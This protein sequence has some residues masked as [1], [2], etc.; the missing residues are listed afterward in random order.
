MAKDKSVQSS[1]K[2]AAGTSTERVTMSPISDD[3]MDEPL[4]SEEAGNTSTSDDEERSTSTP[5]DDEK[6]DDGED[7]A[8]SLKTKAAIGKSHKVRG[9][10]HLS[11]DISG[12][13]P[14]MNTLTDKK[15]SEW[16]YND[17]ETIRALWLETYTNALSEWKMKFT[18]IK[19]RKKPSFE[20]RETAAQ[21]LR[22]DYIKTKKQMA[23]LNR[24]RY[25]RTVAKGGQPVKFQEVRLPTN[26]AT[27]MRYKFS[28]NNPPVPK[29]YMEHFGT[30]RKPPFRL[31]GIALCQTRDP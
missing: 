5:G 29:Y 23:I 13:Y 8:T 1:P 18:T 15:R 25:E 30:Y 19:K 3:S 20:V 21:I 31:F 4:M 14:E 27:E 6:M 2:G 24:E 26:V 28:R 9:T 16:N 17:P 12:M 7:S 10:R 22:T 11:F